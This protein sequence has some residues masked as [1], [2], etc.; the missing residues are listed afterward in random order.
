MRSKLLIYLLSVLKSLS[1][2]QTN[3]LTLLVVTQHKF[4][5]V[6]KRL[7][8]M[9]IRYLVLL[10]KFFTVWQYNAAEVAQKPLQG[11]PVPWPYCCHGRGMGCSIKWLDTNMSLQVMYIESTHRG[12]TCLWSFNTEE[13]HTSDSFSIFNGKKRETQ[14]LQKNH[15]ISLC[16]LHWTKPGRDVSPVWTDDPISGDGEGKQKNEKGSVWFFFFSWK[17]KLR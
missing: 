1:L 17:L 15:A 12:H 7:G 13:T 11:G 2:R 8:S 14:R 4:V 5:G 10:I 3:I 9:K 6:N 16:M